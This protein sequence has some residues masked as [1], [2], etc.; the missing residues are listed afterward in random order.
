MGVGVG[1][2]RSVKGLEHKRVV[3]ALANHIRDNTPV[4]Q[5]QNSAKIQLVL[6]HALIPLELRHIGQPFFVRFGC[7]KL[8]VE[9]IVCQI[10]RIFCS[11][12]TAVAGILY[13][14]MNV[15]CPAYTQ[16]P[17]VIDLDAVIM[18]QIIPNAAVTLVRTL[19]VDALNDL[20]KL[21]IPGCPVALLAGSP[22][23][24]C[25]TRDL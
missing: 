7:L 13:C 23:V 24:V 2:C 11:P 12:C 14:G 5:I 15:S 6:L 16:N 21:F 9:K 8:A 20:G 3:I 25:S 1:L 18:F 22:F 17:L 4:I 10:L 19:F